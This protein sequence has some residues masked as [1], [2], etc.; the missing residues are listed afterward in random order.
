MRALTMAAVLS[1]GLACRAPQSASAAAAPANGTPAT[2]A[3]APASPA[4]APS[5]PSTPGAQLS[6]DDPPR[7][8][9]PPSALGNVP[10]AD[11]HALEAPDGGPPGPEAPAATVENAPCATDADCALTNVG[12]GSC[13]PMLCQPRAVTKLRADELRD[14]EA[15]CAGCPVPLCRPTGFAS[16]A[17]CAAGKC[18]VKHQRIEE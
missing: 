11:G 14:G 13:C 4:G 9:P 16:L 6:P 10:P 12:P 1:M 2:G 15:K 5:A 17:A 7:G 18:T 8:L 3:V